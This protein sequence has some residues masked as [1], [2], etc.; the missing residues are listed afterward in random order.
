MA[1]GL[2]ARFSAAQDASFQAR[3][4]EA[5]AEAAVAINSE[6]ATAKTPA[7]IAYGAIV[8]NDAPPALLGGSAAP[9]MSRHVAAFTLAL[10][11]Q[12]ID[13]SSSDVAISDGVAAVWNA[14]AGA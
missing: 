4:A 2:A 8:L 12:G 10:V 6:A 5:M 3:V 7:R 9:G 1:I 11:G 14:L 13:A